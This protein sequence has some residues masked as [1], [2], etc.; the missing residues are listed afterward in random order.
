M[1]KY[2]EGTAVLFYEKAELKLGMITAMGERG[3]QVLGLDGNTLELIEKR[4][5]LSSQ[6]PLTPMDLQSLHSFSEQIKSFL[7]EFPEDEA[8]Q[9]LAALNQAFSFEEARDILEFSHD[10][11]AF[12]LFLHLRENEEIFAQKKGLFHIRDEEER[13]EFLRQR[14]KSQLRERYLRAVASFLEG[15]EKAETPNLDPEFEENFRLELRSLQFERE[16]KD[17]ARL[18]QLGFSDEGYELRLRDLR[19]A[20]GDIFPN[21]DPIAVTSGIPIAFKPNLSNQALPAK[22]LVRNVATTPSG[23]IPEAFSI[24]IAGTPDFDDAISWTPKENGWTLGIHISDVASRIPL[25]SELFQE[26]R[27]RAASLYLPGESISLLTNLLSSDEFSLLAGTEKPALS[28]YLELDRDLRQ[29]DF[30]F[31]LDKVT[32]KK[33]YSY[34]EFDAELASPNYQPL[35]ALSQN[36]QRER[37]EEEKT[38]KPRFTWHLKVQNEDIFM[39][40]SDNHSPSR[41]IVEELMILYNKLLAKVAIKSGLPFLYRNIA[42][43]RENDDAQQLPQ[44]QAFLS[45]QGKY[46]PGVGSDAYLHATSPIRRFADIVN[47]AQFQAFLQQQTPAFSKAE[48][49]SLIPELEK[50]LLLLRQVARRSESYWLLRFLEQKHLGEPLDLILLKRL[51]QG[52]LAELM[53]WGKRLVI[54]CDTFPPLDTPIKA[55]LTSVDLKELSATAEF[56]F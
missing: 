8:H 37:E 41:Q 21:S 30:Q 19:L 34:Q 39:L 43:F 50:R 14:A 11:Q 6:K 55:I 49:E 27:L 28:L 48:L 54:H 46:H 26:A 42:E 2:A 17:L 45:T 18:L 16:P 3:C 20:L 10:Y 38:E 44:I 31:C 53:R 36:L 22:N 7:K 12:A 25:E 32:I 24:D 40:K 56:G 51:R 1:A 15:F 13:Q 35:R 5:V 9:T 4:F 47:Q 29:Q 52:Y 23:K 33:N